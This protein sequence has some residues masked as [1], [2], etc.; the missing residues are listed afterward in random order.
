MR[1][2]IGPNTVPWVTGPDKME[3]QN[4]ND[5]LVS[6]GEKTGVDLGYHIVLSN[7]IFNAEGMA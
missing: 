3:V 1:N 5:A 4:E 2:K 6:I 7:S